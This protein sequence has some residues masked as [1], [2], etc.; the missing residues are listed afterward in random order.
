MRDALNDMW[1]SAATFSFG[2]D[3]PNVQS[4]VPAPNDRSKDLCAREPGRCDSLQTRTS[5]DTPPPTGV[6]H[7]PH[8]VSCIRRPGRKTRRWR[9]APGGRFMTT[10]G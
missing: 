5:H 9:S 6:M 8:Q 4:L 1:R 2:A 10:E 3:A 7:V